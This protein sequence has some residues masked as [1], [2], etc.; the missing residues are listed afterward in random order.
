MQFPDIEKI[1]I[2][3]EGA[4]VQSIINHFSVLNAI[5]YTDKKIP[6][7]L[8]RNIKYI[9]SN[10]G[11]SWVSAI[12]CSYSENDVIFPLNICKD[13]EIT[14][15]LDFINNYYLEPI[16]NSLFSSDYNIQ[17]I[18]IFEKVEDA[19]SRNIDT[20]YNIYKNLLNLELNL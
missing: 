4:G 5:M 11:G 20:K 7:D 19:I 3:F 14:F 10:S 6:E 15:T 2:S 1:D 12:L 8:L 9:G 18:N 13:N 16:R 17:E